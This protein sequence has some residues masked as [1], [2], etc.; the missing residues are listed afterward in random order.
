MRLTYVALGAGGLAL[1]T[2]SAKARMFSFELLGPKLAL[3]TPAWTIPAFS[4]RNSTAPPL[5][6]LHCTGDIHG[7]GADLR[8]RHHAA[9]AEDLTETADERHHVRGGDAAVEIDRAALDVLDQIFRA[10]DIRTGRL[11]FVRL[12]AAGEHGNADRPARAVRQVAPRRAPSGRR[13]AGRRRGSSR[14]RWSRQTWQW[15]VP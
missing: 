8:V 14:L 1:T 13:D 9:R 11:G 15:R 7:H 4:T 5:D 12:V 2:A 3:P 6:A 10:N